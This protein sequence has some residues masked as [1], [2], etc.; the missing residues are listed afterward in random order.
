MIVICHKASLI[1]SQLAASSLL[2]KYILPRPSAARCAAS[3]WPI[4]KNKNTMKYTKILSL[5]AFASFGLS[6]GS[7]AIVTGVAVHDYQSHTVGFSSGKLVDGSGLSDQGSD[8][9]HHGTDPTDMWI[10]ASGNT[11]SWIEFDLQEVTTL[12]EI[13][14]WNYNQNDAVK[15]GRGADTFDVWVSTDGGTGGNQTI[16]GSWT[17]ITTSPLTL[18]EA[19]GEANYAGERFN[20]A[21]TAARYVR[22]DILTNHGENFTAL[23]EAH[24]YAIPEPGTY[25]LL[26][27]LT[28]LTFVMLRRRR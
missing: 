3:K 14:L 12:S 8:V 15:T 21:D 28:G 4:P 23:S 26:A 11:S 17:K 20:I 6:A 2:I 9:W 13:H 27:G 19:P 25:A 24:F 7:A 22:I 1:V 16:D 10:S 18:D 5:V